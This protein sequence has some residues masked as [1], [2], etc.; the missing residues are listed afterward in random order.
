MELKYTDEQ[1]RG[2]L[3]FT[4]KLGGEWVEV[5]DGNSEFYSADYWDLLTEMWHASRPVM[6]SEALKFMKSIKSPYTARKYL[7]K[8]I[9]EKMVLEKTNP[10]DERSMLVE[11]SPEMA[12]RLDVFFD[13][14]VGGL[15]ELADELKN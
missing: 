7:Q 12:E 13:H 4:R 11:L 5:F 10:Q 14:T 3:R 9:D 15:L 6:V 1:R 2:Y 8:L